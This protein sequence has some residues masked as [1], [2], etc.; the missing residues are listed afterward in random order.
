VVTI[1]KS[2]PKPSHPFV[3]FVFFVFFVFF[4]DLTF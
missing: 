4:V 1:S 2:L 3:P